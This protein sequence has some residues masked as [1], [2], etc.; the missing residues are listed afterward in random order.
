MDLE[1][2]GVDLDDEEVDLEEGVF[3]GWRGGF[4]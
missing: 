1:H 4:G 3:F 2:E